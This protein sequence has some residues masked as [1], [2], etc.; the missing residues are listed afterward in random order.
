MAV[1]LDPQG[2]ARTAAP[3][4]IDQ[5]GSSRHRPARSWQWPV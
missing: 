3:R 1:Q 4:A 2:T 5:R